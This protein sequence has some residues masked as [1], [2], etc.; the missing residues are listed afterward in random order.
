MGLEFSALHF[1]VGGLAVLGV[2]RIWHWERVFRAVH[3]RLE[4][5]PVLTPITCPSCSPVWIGVGVLVVMHVAPL[6]LLAPVAWYPFARWATA[7][8]A[9]WSKVHDHERAVRIQQA[10]TAV[11]HTPPAPPCSNCPSVVSEPPP[12]MRAP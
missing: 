10:L 7:W 12:F 9:W 1:V 2:H 6:W 8:Y 3:R 11:L 5:F 4:A